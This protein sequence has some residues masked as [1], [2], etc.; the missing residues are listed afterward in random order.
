M[1][2]NWMEIQ[3]KMSKMKMNKLKIIYLNLNMNSNRARLHAST[4]VIFTITNIKQL[5]SLIEITRTI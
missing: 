5:S 4:K 2:S 3:V 1:D